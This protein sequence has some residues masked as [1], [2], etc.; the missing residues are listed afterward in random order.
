MWRGRHTQLWLRA[1]ADPLGWP[2]GQVSHR[3]R[4]TDVVTLGVVHPDGEHCRG[5]G[6][7]PERERPLEVTVFGEQRDGTGATL[8][9]G[10][11]IRWRSDSV[12]ARPERRLSVRT[13]YVS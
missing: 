4:A 11:R 7:G 8:A 12:E 10:T 9:D 13:G 3:K 1:D 2:R 6:D 5:L